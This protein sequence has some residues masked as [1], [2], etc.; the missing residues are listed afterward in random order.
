M[1]FMEAMN[2]KMKEIIGRIKLLILDVDGVM[3]DGRI[4]IND[5]GQES[6]FFNVKD[7]HGL[8]M[9]MRSGIDVVLLT[10]RQSAVVEHRAK[11]LGITE[12]HQRVWNKLEVYEEIIRRRGLSDDEVA[13]I[14]DDIVDIPVLRRV[15]FSVSVAD[16]TEETRKSVQ[17][18]SSRRGGDGVVREVCDLIL[19]A[20]G[21]W[22]EIA[23]KYQFNQDV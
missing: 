3:T 20:Q 14:G 15:G 18:V 22:A 19:K 10:G 11:D 1:T 7:G 21:H 8:K 23:H 16:G 2:P 12:I 4:V 17:Y 6:K 13:F 5:L 9:L